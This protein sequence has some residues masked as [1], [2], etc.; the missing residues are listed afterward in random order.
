MRPFLSRMTK[1]IGIG[2]RLDEPITTTSPEAQDAIAIE[3]DWRVVGDDM[4]SAMKQIM[5]SQKH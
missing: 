4:R 3:S 1:A 2:R 5:F